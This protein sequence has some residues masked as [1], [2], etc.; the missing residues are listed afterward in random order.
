M[1]SVAVKRA[2][3]TRAAAL[4]HPDE[5]CD[6]IEREVRRRWSGREAVRGDISGRRTHR[7]AR[8]HLIL[9]LLAT[10]SSGLAMN[11]LPVAAVETLARGHRPGLPPRFA[12]FLGGQVAAGEPAT[13]QRRN[14]AQRTGCGERRRPAGEQDAFPRVHLL[15][16]GHPDHADHR[17]DRQPKAPAGPGHQ[18]PGAI[19]ECDPPE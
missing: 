13:A 7:P 16:V 11:G 12:H 3:G 15:V 2:L 8:R 5:A 19:L 10:P 1:R 17:P 18:V 14:P 6:R 9:R 4:L